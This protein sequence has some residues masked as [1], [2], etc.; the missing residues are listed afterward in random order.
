MGSVNRTTFHLK[1]SRDSI[2]DLWGVQQE[3]LLRLCTPPD[4][5]MKLKPE[6]KNGVKS[7]LVST[8]SD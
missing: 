6:L 1:H 5:K 3:Q 7:W 8:E 2:P 4:R